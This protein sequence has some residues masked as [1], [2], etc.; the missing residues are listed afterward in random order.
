MTIANIALVGGSLD[1]A[2]F[3]LIP[4]LGRSMAPVVFLRGGPWDTTL[5]TSRYK[6]KNNGDANW[7][8]GRPKKRSS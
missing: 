5:K 6:E 1:W 2:D 4:P 8:G 7:H 3:Q